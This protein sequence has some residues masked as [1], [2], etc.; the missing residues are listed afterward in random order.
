MTED[1]KRRKVEDDFVYSTIHDEMV[2]LGLDD[3]VIVDAM[4]NLP[5]N[6]EYIQI[7]WA[8]DEGKRVRLVHKLANMDI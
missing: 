6:T 3:K 2:R 7:F 4:F 8:M 5:R 1:V